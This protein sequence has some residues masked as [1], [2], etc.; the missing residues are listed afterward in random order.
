MPI[1][2]PPFSQYQA[3]LVPLRGLWRRAPPEGDYFVNA[4][5]DWAAGGVG[6]AVQFALSGNSPVSLSQIVA[7]SVDN[8][9]CGADTDFLFP[10]SAFLLTVPAHNQLIAPVFTNALTF[11]AIA[12]NAAAGDVSILQILNS[13]PPPVPI[14]PTA[15]QQSS[16]STGVAIANGTTQL[17]AAGVSGTLEGFQLIVAVNNPA[18]TFNASIALIDGLGNNLWYGNVSFPTATYQTVP[19]T[20]TGLAK[21][22]YN[23]IRMVLTN[24]TGGAGST[25]SPNIYYS[26]P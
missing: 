24:V 8:S 15:L 11:Y 10:D 26:V 23:G 14:Q 20:V 13:M 22:F 1:T 4:E 7:L 17:V 12:A 19:F 16:V 21:R 18:A 25:I 5:I 9:R 3:P 2:I 6:T